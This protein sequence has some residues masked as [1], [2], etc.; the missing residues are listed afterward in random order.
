MRR[1]FPLA[2]YLLICGGF[3]AMQGAMFMPGV[4]LQ[5]YYLAGFGMFLVGALAFMPWT[6]WW[7]S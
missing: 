6:R 7:Q 4:F 1:D 3:G 5:S 2:E